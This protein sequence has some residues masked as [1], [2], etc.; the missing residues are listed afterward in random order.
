MG[1]NAHK[2]AHEKY[3]GFTN[4]DAQIDDKIEK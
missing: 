1:S 2:A 3:I 4:S